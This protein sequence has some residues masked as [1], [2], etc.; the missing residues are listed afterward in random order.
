[1]NAILLKVARLHLIVLLSPSNKKDLFIEFVL[2]F[3]LCKLL[4]IMKILLGDPFVT[5]MVFLPLAYV[6][7][8]IDFVHTIIV[9]FSRIKCLPQYYIIKSKI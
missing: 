1:M 6:L 2:H 8:L 9:L 4:F 5:F 3:Q 7:V